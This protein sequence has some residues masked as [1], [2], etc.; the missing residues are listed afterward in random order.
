M[1][2]VE[3][4]IAE[5]DV[6]AA[7]IGITSR[8]RNRIFVFASGAGAALDVDEVGCKINWVFCLVVHHPSAHSG[9]NAYFTFRAMEGGL[10]AGCVLRRAPLMPMLVDRDHAHSWMSICPPCPPHHPNKYCKSHFFGIYSIR[11]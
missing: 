10:H 2:G 1:T 5:M 3:A 8:Y 6:P 9:A 7:T 4:L 11:L